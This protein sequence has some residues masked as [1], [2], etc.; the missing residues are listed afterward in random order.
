MIWTDEYALNSKIIVL[1][2]ALRQVEIRV[3]LLL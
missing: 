3:P 1:C 2:T